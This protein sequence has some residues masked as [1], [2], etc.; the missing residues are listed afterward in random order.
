MKKIIALLIF[1]IS[2]SLCAQ[3]PKS[4]TKEDLTE[5][6]WF[7][8]SG[9]DE[10]GLEGFISVSFKDD[11]TYSFFTSL[12]RVYIGEGRFELEGKTVIMQPCDNPDFI[13]YSDFF[14]NNKPLEL[15]Y[16]AE[17]KDYH[18]TGVLK[19][20]DNKI[21]LGNNKYPT[22]I[23][24]KCIFDG[25]EVVKIS[26]F[27]TPSD[28]TCFRTKPSLSADT[29]SFV[30]GFYLPQFY[31]EI[32]EKGYE[33]CGF[34]PKCYDVSDTGKYEVP[35]LFKGM[36]VEAIAKTVKNQTIDGITAPWI[37]VYI[38]ESSSPDPTG[39]TAWVFGGYLIKTSNKQPDLDTL[40][41]Q[42]Y[43]KGVLKKTD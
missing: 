13:F 5:K 40:I 41:P 11:L 6:N 28:N 31:N 20:K 18:C 23:G 21:I 26:E 8:S 38:F 3:V 19:S 7:I 17:Y 9:L 32:H 33:I 1:F 22:N 34:E 30:Y 14:F 29:K 43:A 4:F 12:E 37:K 39:F 25:I 16:D 36:V 35:F 27:Y 24:E 15:T 10:Y 2:F 42:A